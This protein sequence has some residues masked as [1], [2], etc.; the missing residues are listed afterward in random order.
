M[1][2]VPAL[3]ISA[4]HS[5]SRTYFHV[6]DAQLDTESTRYVAV[7]VLISSAGEIEGLYELGGRVDA[8]AFSVAHLGQHVLRGVC[9]LPL[10]VRRQRSLGLVE[11]VQ[12]LLGSRHLPPQVNRVLCDDA[13]VVEHSVGGTTRGC[14]VQRP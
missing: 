3:W 7:E 2:V 12:H 10:K 14:A 5:R 13:V 6:H 11:A 1:G 8:A 9:S 4:E